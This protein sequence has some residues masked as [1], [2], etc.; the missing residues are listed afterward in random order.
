L[1]NLGS[2]LAAGDSSTGPRP[3]SQ[4]QHRHDS[5]HRLIRGVVA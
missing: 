2:Y 4:R 1:M 5:I 3:D